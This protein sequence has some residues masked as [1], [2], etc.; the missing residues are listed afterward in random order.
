MNV[1]LAGVDPDAVTMVPDTLPTVAV[2]VER[3]MVQLDLPMH[4]A[5]TA[6]GM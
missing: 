3:A 4:S 2:V 1:V 6:S 5:P